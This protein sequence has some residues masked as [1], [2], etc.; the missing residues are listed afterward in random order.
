MQEFGY[1]AAGLFLPLF[2]LS[3][4][5]NAILGRVGHPLMRSAL[6]VAWPM[7]GL[8]VLSA[9]DDD[10]PSWLVAWALATAALYAFRMLAMRDIT[11]WTGFLASS[12]WALLWLPASTDVE[13]SQLWLH[14]AAFSIP[15]V[16]VTLLSRN[17]EQ[18][19]GAAYIGLYG[20]LALSTPRF[21]GVL[22]ISV[23]AATAT[24]L[25]PSFLSMLGVA[26]AA[27][28]APAIALVLVWFIW[29]WAGA[30]L[31]QGLIVGAAEPSPQSDLRPSTTWGYAAG[32]TGLAVAGLILMGSQL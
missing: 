16:V 22:V 11:R 7:A 29:S 17:L 28:P 23:L 32:L 13:T 5:F 30:R 8:L 3:I 15:L 4:V 24:P 6:L 1:L 26:V 12:A 20:G 21:A 14:A 18:R 10:L 9:L 19:F 31:L 27:D 25:F 2:P